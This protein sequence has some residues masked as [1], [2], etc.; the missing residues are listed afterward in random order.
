MGSTS[1]EISGAIPGLNSWL[2]LV[3]WVLG[4]RVA[5]TGPL[6]LYVASTSLRSGT[7]GA[8]VRGLAG[9]ISL[10]WLVA[11]TFLLRSDFR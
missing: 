1:E 2:R 10:G 7:G 6:A 3:F 9:V 8:L 4:G 5:A 11:V